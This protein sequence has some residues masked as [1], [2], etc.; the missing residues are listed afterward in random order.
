MTVSP[1]LAKKVTPLLVVQYET[2]LSACCRFDK[3]LIDLLSS[4]FQVI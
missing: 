1:L 2:D 4:P 3:L